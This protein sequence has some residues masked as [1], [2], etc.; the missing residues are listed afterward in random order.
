MFVTI[1][2]FPKMKLFKPRIANPTKHAAPTGELYAVDRFLTNHIFRTKT[3]QLGV[4]YKLQGIDAACL[5]DQT[6]ES[7]SQ[8]LLTA[9]RTLDEDFRIYQYLIK[10]DGT[11]LGQEGPYETPAVQ[12]TIHARTEFLK[13]KRLYSIRLFLVI[14][15]EPS[16]RCKPEYLLSRTSSFQ[17]SVNDLLSM[18]LLSK[19][20]AFGLFR[21]LANLDQPLAEAENLKYDNYLDHRVG[22]AMVAC[23]WD[24]ISVDLKHV[25]VLTLR[26][27]PRG[28]F[29]GLLREFLAL[30][31]NFILT[32][33]YRREPNEKAIGAI[34]AAQNHFKVI[35]TLKSWAAILAIAISKLFGST[36]RE[37]KADIVPDASCL[38]N[39]EELKENVTR[40]NN[41]SDYL[42]QFSLT[43]V[44][45][46]PDR[47]KLQGS[48]A[49]A[50]KLI[51]NQEGSLIRETYNALNA[52]R[53][54]LPG[55]HA[56]NF[57][58][59]WMHGRNY[60]DMAL[61]YAPSTGDAINRH[62]NAPCLLTLETT[63]GTPYRFNLHDRDLL[64]VIFFGVMG[65]GKSFTNNLFL[66]HFQKY[67]PLTFV[68]DIGGSYQFTARK[69][70]GAHLRLADH[71]QEFSFNPF[72][73]KRDSNTNEFLSTF[74]QV[75]LELG[76]YRATPQDNRVIDRAVESADRLSDLDIPA[77]LRDQLYNWIGNGRHAYLFDNQ[78][79]TFNLAQFQAI[80]FQGVSDK[81]LPPVF[82]YLFHRIS[83]FIYDPELRSRV[84][85]IEADE[86]VWKFLELKVARSFFIETG[87]TIR[88]H[89]GGLILTTQSPLDLAREGLLDA[90]REICPTWIFGANP[91]GDI[92]FYEKAFG[93]NPVEAQ[94]LGGLIPKKQIFVKTSEISIVLE[95]NA[96]PL[97]AWCYRNDPHSNAARDAAIAAHGFEEGMRVL[98]KGA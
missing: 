20:E 62:L 97:A 87:K 52:Y 80:D 54:V 8:R 12:E 26:E 18:H 64:G 34:N 78:N 23:S 60:V 17:R 41:E 68:L 14:L 65:S 83:Q 76:G 90:L 57:R 37:A 70:A 13:A 77:H 59:M 29:P 47:A 35:S 42:G 98:A 56:H 49:D 73:L 39:I 69:H 40:V 11:D 95:V 61:V 38:A 71:Y 16:G 79:D 4:A 58:Q 86:I 85:L 32:S 75:L 27:P 7:H 92:A 66:D 63:C 82:F 33:E 84:K 91:G 30:D 94:K 6:I 43:L 81:I 72:Q 2:R 51:G 10:H 45:H 88:K 21:L 89:N 22:S 67:D 15:V 48:V 24:G 96:D 5:S 93:M 36:E 31:G 28:T 3:G 53:A 25:E 74:V 19:Q 44:L 9:F 55:G 50:Q 46:S 1:F